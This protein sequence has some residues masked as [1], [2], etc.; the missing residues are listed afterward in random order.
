MFRKALLV[1][2]ALA[3]SASIGVSSANAG[4]SLTELS[5]ADL[6][7][8]QA[9]IPANP[10]KAEPARVKSAAP[11]V[12]RKAAPKVVASLTS[13]RSYHIYIHGVTY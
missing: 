4:L 10:E 7:L 6:A 1:C 12:T 2:A 13:P 8:A 3:V 11:A 5:E 9:T